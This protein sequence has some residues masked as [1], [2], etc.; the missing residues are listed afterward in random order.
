MKLRTL[1]SN[2]YYS[3]GQ[4]TIVEIMQIKSLNS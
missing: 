3:V 4:T 1:A 2:Q